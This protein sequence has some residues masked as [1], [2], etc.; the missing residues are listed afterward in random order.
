MRAQYVAGFGRLKNFTYIYTKDRVMTNVTKYNQM[1]LKYGKEI[2]DEV[3]AE[4]KKADGNIRWVYQKF[5]EKQM[6]D[7]AACLDEY[8]FGK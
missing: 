8:F 6:H 2:I 4:A 5:E 3:K 7:H 1:V